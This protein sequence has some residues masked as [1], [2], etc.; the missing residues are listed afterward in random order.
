MEESQ[1][2]AARYGRTEDIKERTVLDDLQAEVPVSSKT[3][4]NTY[5]VQKYIK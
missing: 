5:V 1:E 3:H 2:T 4:S